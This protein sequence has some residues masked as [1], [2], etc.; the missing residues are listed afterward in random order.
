MVRDITHSLTHQHRDKQPAGGSR[1][2]MAGSGSGE[3][4]TKQQAS[5]RQGLAGKKYLWVPVLSCPSCP[6]GVSWGAAC[7]HKETTNYPFSIPVPV[8][9]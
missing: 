9:I 5:Q 7:M 8:S 4:D 1:Q 6:I 3:R 2:S